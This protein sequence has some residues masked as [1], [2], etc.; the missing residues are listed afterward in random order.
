MWDASRLEQVVTNLL[1]NA[2]KF[3]PGRPIEIRARKLDGDAELVM[4]DHGIGIDP[5]R[6]PH[7]FERFER[8]VPWTH[9]GGLGLGLYITRCIVQ[10]HGGTVRAESTVGEGTTITVR[11]PCAAPQTEEETRPSA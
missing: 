3:G 10:A 9:Y 1:A 4:R 11:L 6:L 2:I 5:A 7:V 8:A